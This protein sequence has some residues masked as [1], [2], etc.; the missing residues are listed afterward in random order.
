MTGA[1]SR[2]LD[3]PTHAMNYW[4]NPRASAHIAPYDENA[5]HELVHTDVS[6]NNVVDPDGR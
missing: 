1:D 4:L 5:N 6:W 3:D 2:L